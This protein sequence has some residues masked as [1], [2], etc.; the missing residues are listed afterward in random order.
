MVPVI[1]TP[2][3]AVGMPANEAS[4]K[5]VTILMVTAILGG[6]GGRSKVPAPKHPIP[7]QFSSLRLLLWEI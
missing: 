2:P 1:S 3:W 4:S 5:N 6:W 7:K